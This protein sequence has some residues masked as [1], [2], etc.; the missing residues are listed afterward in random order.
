MKV[1]IPYKPRK[2]F[3][4]FHNRTERFAI[5]AAHRRAGKTVSCVNDLILK[6]CKS[7]L[8]AYRA[9]YIAPFR[10]QTNETAWQYLKD[11]A[12]SV[13]G[14]NKPNEGELYIKLYNGA[15]IRVLGA[16]NEDALRGA[17]LD[18]VVLDEF[19][20]MS[21]SIWGSIACWRTDKEALPSL[22]H[23]KAEIHSEISFATQKRIRGGTGLY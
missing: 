4:P 3:L 5:I 9:A 23:R 10:G 13:M 2:I 14:G 11:Y 6:A 15:R 20:D 12:R 22:A 18:N 8:P 7:T 16:D 21:P 17:Y 1:V 19:P